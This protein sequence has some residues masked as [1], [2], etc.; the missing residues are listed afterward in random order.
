[1]PKLGKH[2]FW[3]ESMLAIQDAI[4]TSD[5]RVIN[6]ECKRQIKIYNAQNGDLDEGYH[7]SIIPFTVV[8]EDG[9]TTYG[10]I[11]LYGY[12]DRRWRLEIVDV[13]NFHRLDHRRRPRGKRGGVERAL[14]TVQNWAFG[15]ALALSY[16]LY[17][18]WL[19]IPPISRLVGA[20]LL[21]TSTN[22]LWTQRV[23]VAQTNRRARVAC[24]KSIFIKTMEKQVSERGVVRQLVRTRFSSGAGFVGPLWG[25][26]LEPGC[27]FEGAVLSASGFKCKIE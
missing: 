24:F 14:E 3:G 5:A 9:A 10:L 19:Q 27:T 2:H 20:F 21:D 22:R 12:E 4:P 6:M 16:V 15:R 13:P 1:M 11:L 25:F 17:S 23:A 8:G 26:E 7:A 18:A